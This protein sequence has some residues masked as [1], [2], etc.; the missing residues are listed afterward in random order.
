[1]IRIIAAIDNRLGIA[2]ENGIPWRGKLPSDIAYYR[3]HIANTPVIMGRGVYDELSNPYPGAVNYVATTDIHPL[4]HGFTPIPDAGSFLRGYKSDIWILGGAIL[5]KS[6]LNLAGEL[7]LT[8]IEN[9]FHCTKFFPHF[10]HLFSLKSRSQPVLENK[11]QLYFE[12]WDRK[13]TS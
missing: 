5:Y 12:V 13:T 2:D 6:T 9:D 10:D 8:R 4:R 3:S 7:Y 1:V 11:L